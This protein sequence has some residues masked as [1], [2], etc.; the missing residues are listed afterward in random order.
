MTAAKPAE[1]LPPKP[2]TRRKYINATAERLL[3]DCFPGMIPA[4]VIED[5]LRQKA[6]REGR[7]TPPSQARRQP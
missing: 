3:A 2:S 4:A 1:H 7:L 5:A 6:I